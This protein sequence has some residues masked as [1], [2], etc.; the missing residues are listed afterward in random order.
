MTGT[1]E[2]KRQAVNVTTSPN[3]FTERVSIGFELEISASVKANIYDLNGRLAKAFVEQKMAAG[4]QAL[5]WEAGAA[6]P[7]TYIYHL[8][9]EGRLASGILEVVR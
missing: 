2:A 5:T 7:G 9:V 8:L 1:G 3:P 6:L 4:T